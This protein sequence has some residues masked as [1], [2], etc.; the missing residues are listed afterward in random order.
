VLPHEQDGD[1]DD[2]DTDTDSTTCHQDKHNHNHRRQISNRKCYLLYR[3]LH[4][5]VLSVYHH[6][7]LRNF[8]ALSAESTILAGLEKEL[9]RFDEMEASWAMDR[10]QLMERR[11]IMFVCSYSGTKE[12]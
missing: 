1:N 3:L 4:A 2:N 11:L 7:D 9:M 8:K 10:H 12:L 5:A 6:L